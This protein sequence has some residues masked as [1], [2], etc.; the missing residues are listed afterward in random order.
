MPYRKNRYAVFFCNLFVPGLNSTLFFAQRKLVFSI[1]KIE[2]SAEDDKIPPMQG[3]KPNGLGG[4][5]GADTGRA[6]CHGSQ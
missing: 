6:L 4:G 1:P 5:Q 2:S 3:E